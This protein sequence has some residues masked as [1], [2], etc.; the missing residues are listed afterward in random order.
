MKFYIPQI[1]CVTNLS[2][3][4][5]SRPRDSGLASKELRILGFQIILSYPGCFFLGMVA[6]FDFAHSYGARSSDSDCY[7]QN[8]NWLLCICQIFLDF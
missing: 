6:P 1:Q 4:K 7:F 8:L 3:F 5:E 2:P